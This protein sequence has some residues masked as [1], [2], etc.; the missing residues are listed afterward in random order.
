[1]SKFLT[2][3]ELYRLTDCTKPAEQAAFLQRLG[4]RPI[5]NPKA[6]C[7]YRE[8]IERHML[9]ESTDIDVEPDI[10]WDSIR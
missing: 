10:N 7:I 8:I 5:V 4:L 2:K 1:M 3:S 9:G 6:C